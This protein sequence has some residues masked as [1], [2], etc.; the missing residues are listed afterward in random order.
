MIQK[1]IFV[2]HAWR[3]VAPPGPSS[4][5][6]PL[7]DVRPANPR[8]LPPK[9]LPGPAPPTGP[10]GSVPRFSRVVW[11]SISISI[12]SDRCSRADQ[13]VWRTPHSQYHPTTP[14]FMAPTF[15]HVVPGTYRGRVV[16]EEAYAEMECLWAATVR[17][18]QLCGRVWWDAGG[19]QGCVLPHSPRVSLSVCLFL[20]HAER[21][22]LCKQL[23]KECKV[24]KPPRLAVTHPF[25]C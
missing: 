1:N 14:N 21:G 12:S 5:P 10:P 6:P 23:H 8:E 3:A 24:A 20:K 2:Q 9:D 15:K 16:T 11:I 13:A 7:P 25:T 19:V 22:Q 18:R 4:S 17:R